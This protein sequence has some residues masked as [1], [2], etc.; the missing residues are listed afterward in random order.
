MAERRL[1]HTEFCGG[2]GEAALLG[3]GEEGQQIIEVAALHLSI[4]V[5]S[6]CGL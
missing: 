4:A 2:T 6:P 3:N 1:G 5:I